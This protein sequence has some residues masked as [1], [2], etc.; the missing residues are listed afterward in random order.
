MIPIWLDCDPGHD[1]AVAILLAAKLPAFNLLGIST[2]F[3]N[4]PLEK[5]TVNAMAV[6]KAIG[7]DSE[8]KVYPG[9][10]RI[11]SRGGGGDG[12]SH[13]QSNQSHSPSSCSRGHYETAPS[14]FAPSIHGES[15]LDGTSL[16]PEITCTIEPHVDSTLVAMANAIRNNPGTCLVAT[17]SLTNVSALF[18]RFPDV[19]NLVET[20]SIMG[21]GFGMGNW[22]P[23]AEFNIWCDAESASQVLGDPIVAA[24]VV[25]CPLNVTHTAIAT[26]EVLSQIKSVGGN[27]SQMFFEL[28]TF[29]KE[30]YESEFG[31]KDGPPVHDPLSVA[32]LLNGIVTK[33]RRVTVD[34]TVG[35]EQ[36]GMLTE[37]VGG[38]LTVVEEVDLN[39]FWAL[40]V[41]CLE[42]CK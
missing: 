6:L 7:Q 31:F 1:D 26:E 21:G 2:V 11:Q 14:T 20:V 15:G 40:V 42:A 28:M 33:E 34:V 29:F 32:V 39:K 38:H 8:I 37:Q 3:G 36:R 30:T 9:A 13:D 35:G 12:G 4:A 18:D 27:V 17:G 16:L 25:L 24:K 10:E 5:T 23:Y 41:T 19:K 22:T